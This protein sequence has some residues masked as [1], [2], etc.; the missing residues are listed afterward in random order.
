MVINF[1]I[2]FI[3]IFLFH[4]YLI[5]LYII[6]RFFMNIN[7]VSFM[8][9]TLLIIIISLLFTNNFVVYHQIFIIKFRVFILSYYSI[10]IVNHHNHFMN[11]KNINLVLTFLI[12]CLFDYYVY[13]NDVLAY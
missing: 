10:F 9:I 1:F 6:I 12:I 13:L 2:N 11:I 4:I 7:F 8:H 3:M 5:L